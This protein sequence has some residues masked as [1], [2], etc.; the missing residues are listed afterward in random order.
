M[1][2]SGCDEQRECFRQRESSASMSMD[3]EEGT[4]EGPEAAWLVAT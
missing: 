1:S 3:P 2:L 4:E